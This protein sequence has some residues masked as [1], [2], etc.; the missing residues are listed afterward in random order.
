M[1]AMDLLLLERVRSFCDRAARLDAQGLLFQHAALCARRC[2]LH[3][4]R[5]S[6]NEWSEHIR[7]GAVRHADSH[8]RDRSTDGLM[9]LRPDRID[10]ERR[11]VVEEKSSKSH[12][13]ATEDQLSFYV[14]MLTGATGQPWTGRL[15]L[16]GAKRYREVV[17]DAGRLRRLEGALELLEQ[18]KKQKRPPKTEEVAVCIGCSN[19]EFCSVTR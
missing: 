18:L 11:V 10:W 13:A 15:Y 12:A 19:A 7:L 4:N 2:W 14:A 3:F 8:A 17:L 16:L 1:S 5:A 6:M 9:G